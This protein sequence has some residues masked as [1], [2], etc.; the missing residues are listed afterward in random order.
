MTLETAEVALWCA[1]VALV[2]A[3]ALAVYGARLTTQLR[4]QVADLEEARAA[5]DTALEHLLTTGLPAVVASMRR[6]GASVS[7]FNVAGCLQGSELGAYLVRVTRW[8]DSQGF[9]MPGVGAG[10]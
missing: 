5:R 10:F 6:P 9:G 2:G 8:G 4:I 3:I 1:G 7:G